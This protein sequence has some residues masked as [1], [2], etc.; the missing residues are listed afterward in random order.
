[1]FNL[2]EIFP[3]IEA[4][5]SEGAITLYDWIGDSWCIFFSHPRDYTPVCTTELGRAATLA[6]EFEKRNCKV[7]ALSCDGVEDHVAWIEDIKAICSNLSTFPF[8]IIADKDR[9]IAKKLG[10]IDPD[11]KDEVGMPLTCRALF[12]I[13]K[14]RKLKLSM[15]YPATTGRN[16]DEILRALDSLQLTAVEKV[17]TPA[18]WTTSKPCFVVPSVS[19]EEAK[20]QFPDHKVVEVPSKKQY[21][22]STSKFVK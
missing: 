7:I 14:D 4:E 22:R 5:T 20:A 11:E 6:P 1:M 13:G 16:F 19:P 18:D 8:P 3:N 10:M 9:A 15:R 12:I 2:G 17:A 21:I